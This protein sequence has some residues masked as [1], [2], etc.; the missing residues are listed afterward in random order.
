MEPKIISSQ[1]A[2][3]SAY[4]R[5]VKICPPHIWRPESLV[6]S[7]FL[8]EPCFRLIDCFQVVLLELGPDHVG[9]RVINDSNMGLSS[10]GAKQVENF[11]VG[12]KRPI[13]D[14]DVLNIKRQKVDEKIM[15]FDATMQVEEKHAYIVTCE[16]KEDYATYMHTS[17]LSFL[18]FLKSSAVRPDTSRLD[19]AL[20]ALSM[21]CIAFSSYS[22]TNLSLS[23][24]EQMFSWMP[25]ILEQ[26]YKLIVVN[27]PIS[28]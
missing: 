2:L 24:F 21:L 28:Y 14:V 11:R 13:H 10:G 23:I 8:P 15:A 16:T 5:I 20:T 25:W 22:E 7:F 12:E 9:G 6:Y 19:L 26:V 4:I 1:V 27:F 3:C 18:E 17:I